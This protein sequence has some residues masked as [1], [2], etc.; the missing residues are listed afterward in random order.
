MEYCPEGHDV[1][2]AHTNRGEEGGGRERE[3]ERETAL[4]TISL[5]KVHKNGGENVTF[6]FLLFVLFPKEKNGK[7]HW[8][9][10]RGVGISI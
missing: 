6:I 9:V 10:T 8:K 7:M 1:N 2:V 3:R 5:F 4:M